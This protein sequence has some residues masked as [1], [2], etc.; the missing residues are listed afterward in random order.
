ME[1]VKSAAQTLFN[2]S[3]KDL[4]LDYLEVG[5]DSII[6]NELLKDL[7]IVKTVHSIAKVSLAIKEK[8][9][10]KKFL[11]F[12]KEFNSGIVK[13]KE[14]IKRKKA[15][16]NNEEWIHKEIEYLVIYIE[17]LDAVVKARILAVLYCDFVN[18]KIDW[19]KY[20]QYMEIV[21]RMFTYDINML[22]IFYNYY[23][24]NEMSDEKKFISY[25][26]TAYNRLIGLGLMI[27]DIDLGQDTSKYGNVFK[28]NSYFYR[29]TYS[30]KYVGNI[31]NELL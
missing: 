27:R 5:I 14:V 28:Y 16:E 6:D 31:I 2:D 24:Q 23:S 13:E 26:L 21:N 18:K 20:L 22:K 30:G 15:I 11:T 9:F 29:I 25:D 12:I 1:I 7:P 8:F 17:N 19:E 10:L 3:V 4:S